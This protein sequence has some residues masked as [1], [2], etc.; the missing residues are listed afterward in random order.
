MRRRNRWGPPGPESIPV[1]CQ[2]RVRF[3]EADALRVVWHGHYLSYFEEGRTAFGRAYG[4]SYQAILE[5]GFIAPLVHVELDYFQP[6]AFDQVLEVEARLHIDAGARIQFTYT[7]RDAES[8]ATLVTGRSVQVFTETDG[9]L[10][11]TRP[12]F[13][14][15][16]LAD[17]AHLIQ[18]ET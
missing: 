11:L 8:E 18:S 2:V 7:V 14:S 10:V 3:Q 12:E 16:F 9:T 5:A 17:H 1:T 15:Q 6:A 4:F 13:F